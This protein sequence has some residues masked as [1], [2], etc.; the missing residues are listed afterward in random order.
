MGSSDGRCSPVSGEVRRKAPSIPGLQA[1]AGS[2]PSRPGRMRALCFLENL[3]LSSC[4]CVPEMTSSSPP[5][6]PA[7]LQNR[8][9]V[10]PRGGMKRTPR[11]LSEWTRE[12][13]NANPAHSTIHSDAVHPSQERCPH[14][15]EHPTFPPPSWQSGGDKGHT[16]GESQ[17]DPQAPGAA[18]VWAACLLMTAV[19]MVRYK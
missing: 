18:L 5:K 10:Q 3:S 15:Q 19:V 6:S 17:L 11:T 9:K 16:L 1:D 12:V 4:V 2:R 8:E 13:G 14:N 7:A